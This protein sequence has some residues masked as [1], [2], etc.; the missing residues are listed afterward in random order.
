[1]SASTGPVRRLAATLRAMPRRRG[2]PGPLRGRV[3]SVERSSRAKVLIPPPAAGR[4]SCPHL[5]PAWPHRRAA[6]ASVISIII[7]VAQSP[8]QDVSVH[9]SSSAQPTINRSEAEQNEA[10]SVGRKVTRRR[11]LVLA[12]SHLNRRRTTAAEPPPPP[13]TLAVVEP[14]RNKTPPTTANTGSTRWLLLV[15]Y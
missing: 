2:R 9:P 1:V 4:R 11:A 3:V 14:R 5:L 15:N 7:S 6:A 13:T 12:R 10:K 8:V